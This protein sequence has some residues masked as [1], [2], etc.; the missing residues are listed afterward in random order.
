MKEFPTLQSFTVLLTLIFSLYLTEGVRRFAIRFRIGDFPDSSRK[1]HKKVMP[2]LGGLAIFS[3]FYLGFGALYFLSEPVR[4][5]YE[6]GFSLILLTAIPIIAIGIYDDIRGVNFTLKFSIQVLA[7]V[8]LMHFGDLRIE[9]I[10]DP[11]STQSVFIPPFLSMPLTVLWLV[12]I[13]NAINLIDGLDG[14]AAG[15]SGIAS[16]ALCVISLLTQDYVLALLFLLLSASIFGFLKH[17]YAPASIFMGDTGALFIG[18]MLGALT[19]Y[20]RHKS[21][22]AIALAV[23]IVILAIPIIDTLLAPIRRILS[24]KHPFK[25]D[26]EHIHHRVMQIFKFSHRKTVLAI[27]GASLFFSLGAILIAYNKPGISAAVFIVILVALLS[28]IIALGYLKP[29]ADHLKLPTRLISSRRRELR[30][31]KKEENAPK[32]EAEILG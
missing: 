29:I 32:K 10:S 8:S 1:I 13:C 18:Y 5:F 28:S 26:K 11:F 19:I 24:G 20:Y 22:A 17:N 4:N 3:S 31:M 7:A 21:S 25:A 14:L 27:Y 15:V 12:G 16:I 6:S 30:V 23:P 2:S 9:Y